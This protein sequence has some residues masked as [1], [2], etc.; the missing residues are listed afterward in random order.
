MVWEM[1][2]WYVILNLPH[3]M[4]K[5]SLICMLVA[6]IYES[7][8]VALGIVKRVCSPIPGFELCSRCFDS[9]A[10]CVDI[11]QWYEPFAI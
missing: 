6:H 2:V 8:S 3:G 4:D 1:V 5:F 11:L 9:R 7:V 10:F